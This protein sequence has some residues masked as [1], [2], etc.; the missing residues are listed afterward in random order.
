MYKIAKIA[1]L[2]GVAV[3]IG[4][5]SFY[6][7]QTQIANPP[8]IQCEQNLFVEDLKQE[9]DK[10]KNFYAS[11]CESD[12]DSLHKIINAKFIIN[13]TNKKFALID[14][15]THNNL[16]CDYK[17]AYAKQ[18]YESCIC[19]FS[20]PWKYA[21]VKWRFDRLTFF[22][23]NTCTLDTKSKENLASIKKIQTDYKAATNLLQQTSYV[24][25]VTSQ[26]RINVSKNYLMSYLSN[27]S[28][29]AEKLRKYPQELERQ[30][31]KYIDAKLNALEKLVTNDLPQIQS[32]INSKSNEL[33][34]Y[35]YNSEDYSRLKRERQ[36]LES[37]YDNKRNQ[38]KQKRENVVK[39]IQ[40]YCNN[41]K[42]T[43]G[44][45]PQPTDT[46]NQ[47]INNI[48]SSFNQL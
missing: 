45:N 4:G 36:E 32:D 28:E 39:D 7:Y 23:S 35:D 13:G 26:K 2:A 25:L 11:N 6:W 10:M 41:A 37:Q 3:V 9:I 22:D 40:D 17:N 18:F 20:K 33:R 34:F 48:K 19:V 47:K 16:L 21:E 43:Y 44:V 5:V 42:K 24:G 38:Y 1:I 29:I 15:E 12:V 46:W 31:R 14:E 30:H 8:D 27:C